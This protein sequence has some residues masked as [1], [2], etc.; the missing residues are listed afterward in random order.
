MSALGTEAASRAPFSWRRLMAI[1]LRHLYVLRSSW[2]RILELAYWPTVQMI[3]WGFI[4]TFFT[5]HSTWLSQASAV[6]ITGVLLWDVLFRANLGFAVPFVEEMYARNLG[7]LFISP[8]RPYEFVVALMMLSGIRTL[9]GVLP[10]SFLAAPLFDVWVYGMGL[11][12]IA[13]FTN[14]IVMGWSIGLVASGIII[15]NGL[16]AENLIWFSVFLLAPVSGI[17][18]PITTLPT[19]LQPVAKLLPSSH[20]FEGMRAVLFEGRF[21]VPHLLWAIGLNFVYLALASLFF[22][23]MFRSA[24]RLGLI[25]HQGE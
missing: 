11:P 18:Y 19:W 15:R 4:T 3:L 21:D 6:L 22:L 25:L 16:G 7:Q 5:Q 20:V 14:L 10:A 2:P 23:T 9:I 1:N 12:L 24:R 17:Y 8:L 13:Y